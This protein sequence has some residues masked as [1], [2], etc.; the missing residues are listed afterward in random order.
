VQILLKVVFRAVC[1]WEE[2]FESWEDLR[3]EDFNDRWPGVGL[4]IVHWLRM[5]PIYWL[6]SP[7]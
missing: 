1:L 4:F 6:P 5:R 2:E 7:Q 3:D